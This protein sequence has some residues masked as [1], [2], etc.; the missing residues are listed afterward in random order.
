MP[1]DHFEIS[2]SVLTVSGTLFTVISVL[3]AALWTITRN[4]NKAFA[5]ALASKASCDELK[6]AKQ[7]MQLMVDRQHQ[8]CTERMMVLTNK[9]DREVDQ[10]Q[11]QLLTFGQNLA[12]MR[13]EN[14]TGMTQIQQTI[15]QVALQLS[16]QQRATD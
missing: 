6:D 4:E 10:L 9:S 5:A 14:S 16:R 1:Q 12:A 8:D 2:N 3:V 11:Q 13:L 7:S 15:Q